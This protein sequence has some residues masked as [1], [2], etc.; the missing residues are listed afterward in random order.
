MSFCWL[1]QG[2]I[3]ESKDLNTHKMGPH[4]TTFLLGPA[5]PV[6]GRD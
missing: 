2:E 1:I 5:L 6:A 3:K 4:G